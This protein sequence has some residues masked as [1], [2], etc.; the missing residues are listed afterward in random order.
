[1]EKTIK[2]KVLAIKEYLLGEFRRGSQTEISILFET[3]ENKK[4]ILKID[5]GKPVFAYA[6]HTQVGD[7]IEFSK[8]D[9]YV[10]SF[11]NITQG[12]S[13]KEE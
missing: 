9:E 3:E 2:A 11:T 6:I 4:G 13:S 12:I 7:D 5:S 8:R 10:T 1:M